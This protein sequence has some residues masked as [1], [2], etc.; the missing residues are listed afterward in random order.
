MHSIH[1]IYAHRVADLIPLRLSGCSNSVDPLQVVPHLDVYR[2]PKSRQERM[3]GPDET[4]GGLGAYPNSLLSKPTSPARVAVF[5]P[6]IVHASNSKF[7]SNF[8]Q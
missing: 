7:V 2:Q 1:I 3:V 4:V 6:E 8:P 5:S